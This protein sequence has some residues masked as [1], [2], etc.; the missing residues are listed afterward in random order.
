MSVDYAE[1]ARLIRLGRRAE[2]RGKAVG[3][4]L[5][6]L[7]TK[8]VNDLLTGWLVMLAVGIA[9]AEWIR[10]LP[11]IGFWWSVLLVSLT[12]GLFAGARSATKAK[13]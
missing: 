10:A 12:R 6:L 5:A 11:T 1:A 4:C 7:L 13:E 9:H 8:I 2:K 3:G